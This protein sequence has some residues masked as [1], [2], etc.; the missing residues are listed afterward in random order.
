MWT[1][2]NAVGVI[3]TA[4]PDRQFGRLQHAANLPK[5]TAGS[6]NRD[7]LNHAWIMLHPTEAQVHA[8]EI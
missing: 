8:N 6:H 3:D 7:K 2:N 1:E 4:Y 5:D